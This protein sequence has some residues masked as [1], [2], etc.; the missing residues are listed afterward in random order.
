[1]PAS[2][3]LHLE[4]LP[5]LAS[6]A[7]YVAHFNVPGILRAGGIATAERLLNGK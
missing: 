1:M 4:N 6:D 5:A 2:V 3:P 7:D